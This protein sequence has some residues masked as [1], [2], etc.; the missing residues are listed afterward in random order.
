MAGE[1]LPLRPAHVRVA[2]AGRGRDARGVHGPDRRRRRLRPR[3]GTAGPVPLRHRAQPGA[4]RPRPRARR[5]GWGGRA[6]RATGRRSAGPS[7]GA[8]RRTCRTAGRG[9]A[10]GALPRSHRALRPRTAQLR[11]RGRGPR[12]PGGHRAFPPAPGPRDARRPSARAAHAG[13]GSRPM[14]EIDDEVARALAALAAAD[15]GRG[16][17]P[18]LEAQLR[19]SFRAVHASRGLAP[20]RWPRPLVFA[21]VAAALVAAAAAA[22]VLRHERPRPVNVRHALRPEAEFAP[23]V[24]GEPLDG[25]DALHLTRIRVERSAL[26]SFGF[27]APQGE[28]DGPPVEAEVLV[29]QDGLARGIRFVSDDG[30]FRR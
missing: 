24:F 22:L 8:R 13:G 27:P 3:A 9:R 19:E 28:E 16:A 12:L 10:P 5:P 7:G 30:G 26:A 21:S 18:E 15:A 2:G 4:A 29:G 1:S 25:A 6:R 17:P 14:N 11:R 23:L 20:R